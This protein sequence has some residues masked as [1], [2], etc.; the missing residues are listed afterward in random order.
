M[1]MAR[2][3]KPC[4]QQQGKSPWTVL[5]GAGVS[6]AA[7]TAIPPW[8]PLIRELIE[9]LAMRANAISPIAGRLTG[10]ILGGLIDKLPYEQVGQQLESLL[11]EAYHR[12]FAWM[13]DRPPNDNH[14]LLAGLAKAGIIRTFLTTNFD[15]CIEKALADAGVDFELFV[16]DE[17]L[18]NLGDSS[19]T[20][21][22]V[23]KLHGDPKT[24]KGFADSLIAKYGVAAQRR[25]QAA[26]DAAADGP[27]LVIG[28]S[29]HDLH[30][31]PGYLGLARIA[32]SASNFA[33]LVRSGSQPATG[34]Q[35]LIA[36]AANGKVHTGDLPGWLAEFFEIGIPETKIDVAVKNAPAPSGFDQALSTLE[37][38]LATVAIAVL[39][40]MAGD[41]A[42]AMLSED[43]LAKA[44][45]WSDLAEPRFRRDGLAAFM[46]DWP[47][48]EEA[49]KPEYA[50][51]AGN[52][53]VPF[54]TVR[55]VNELR[56]L[57]TES[58][59]KAASLLAM[60]YRSI[61]RPMEAVTMAVRAVGFQAMLAVH[62]IDSHSL[63]RSRLTE[64]LKDTANSFYDAGYPE[65]AATVFEVALRVSDH[66]LASM[67]VRSDYAGLLQWM[68]N[69]TRARDLL[70]GVYRSFK[71]LGDLSNAAATLSN[72]ATLY[73]PH[74]AL[75]MLEEARELF[76]KLQSHR[77]VATTWL[78]IAKCRRTV[79]DM[80]G[81]IDAVEM[82][83]KVATGAELPDLESKLYHEHAVTVDEQGRHDE[84]LQLYDRALKISQNMNDVAEVASILNN[85]ARCHR[86]RRDAPGTHAARTQALVFYKQLIN[87]S[88]IAETYFA[89]GVDH[90]V[91]KTFQDALEPLEASRR[92]AREIGDTALRH[93]AARNIVHSL[94]QLGRNTEAKAVIKQDMAENSYLEKS[95]EQFG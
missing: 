88:K 48:V 67:S 82:G 79:Q 50:A 77:G 16:G 74:K 69:R 61:G 65:D 36:Q 76:E 57:P 51:L 39:H 7:P 73:P 41:P 29:G 34:I 5:L 80:E 55:V 70:E 52:D 53:S 64:Y 95:E 56:S 60:H 18:A 92:I 15:H 62:D 72:I 17:E 31:D 89:S 24:G 23:V 43:V 9:V 33:W 49:G 12:A 87:Q 4:G 58:F 63:T 42:V 85:I 20:S 13:A 44:P 71:T 66:P 32:T 3:S 46:V 54:F 22:R 25:S 94:R 27:F 1:S 19:E 10:N 91:F 30:L 26:L 35:T 11:G 86:D 14:R 93:N 75:G 38:H 40:Q 6:I 2:N 90:I 83:L 21:V 84:A 28:F 78:A 37:P 8:L 59:A 81:V 47:N 45:G 68:G